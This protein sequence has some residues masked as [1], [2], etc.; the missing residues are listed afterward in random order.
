MSVMTGVH[1]IPHV[2][3]MWQA[4]LL[5]SGPFSGTVTGGARTSRPEG[6]RAGAGFLGR[7]QRAPSPPARGSGGAL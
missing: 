7:G 4:G 3:C 6:P 1:K 5:P 2:G